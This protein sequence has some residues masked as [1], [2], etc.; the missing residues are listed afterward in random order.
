[1]GTTHALKSFSN[2][3]IPNSFK[4]CILE[5]IEPRARPP[6]LAKF[7]ALF[8]NVHFSLKITPRYLYVL[9]VSS[10]LL[11]TLIVMFYKYK[12]I[13]VNLFFPPRFFFVFFFF[14]LSGNFI[15]IAPFPDHY[16]LEPF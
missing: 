15:M 11:P 1:M 14:F 3:L 4:L 13:I 12:Y 6:A 10:S 16:P 2:V 7:S 8:K 5:I 9:T